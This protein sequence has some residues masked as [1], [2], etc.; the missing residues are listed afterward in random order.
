[1]RAVEGTD[2]SPRTAVDYGLVPR[3]R[4]G[5]EALS[6]IPG[7]PYEVGSAVVVWDLKLHLVSTV[8]SGRRSCLKVSDETRAALGAVL[9]QDSDS[10]GHVRICQGFT[11]G[12]AIYESRRLDMA[13]R[14]G[15]YPSVQT[16]FHR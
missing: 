16:A 3:A 1:M 14:T 8:R 9:G 6:I 15:A 13:R 2:R 10:D 11:G 5:K 4:N 7:P 12:R